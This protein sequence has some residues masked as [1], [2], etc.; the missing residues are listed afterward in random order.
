MLTYPDIDP[1]AIQLGPVAIHW[2]G[3]MGQVLSA[4]M[5]L[6]GLLLIVLAYRQTARQR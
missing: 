1:V 4:P 6:L 3:L 5:I 2:Y